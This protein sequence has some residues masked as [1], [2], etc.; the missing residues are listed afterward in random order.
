MTLFQIN[1]KSKVYYKDIHWLYEAAININ[2]VTETQ[3][4][5]INV[6]INTNKKFSF[7]CI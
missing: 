1:L 3:I 5:S 7:I 4:V 2:A 6:K